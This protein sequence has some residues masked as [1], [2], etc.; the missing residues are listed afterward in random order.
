MNQRPSSEDRDAHPAGD[1][2]GEVRRN[3]EMYDEIAALV[4][5]LAKTFA[6]K[7]SEAAAALES[8]NMKLDFAAD[9]N[10]NRFVAATFSGKTAR[11]YKDAI[12]HAVPPA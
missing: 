3:R 2:P 6:L 10:G 7:E 4:G 5:A 12:K 9:A 1:T 8:G 11:I